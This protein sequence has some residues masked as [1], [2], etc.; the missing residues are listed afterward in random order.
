MGSASPA[1]QSKVVIK[2]I[3]YLQYINSFTSLHLHGCAVELRSDLWYH[4]S[5][6]TDMG[7]N[8]SRKLGDPFMKLRHRVCDRALLT[9]SVVC[10]S[11]MPM[12]SN[13]L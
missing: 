3:V 12:Y 9:L 7:T 5:D 8:P 11:Y 6:A 10:C 1:R 4:P 13:G 2:I